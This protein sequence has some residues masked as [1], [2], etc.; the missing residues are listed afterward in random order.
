MLTRTQI[1]VIVGLTA[2]LWAAV[3]VTRGI[4]FT[5]DQFLAFGAT[6]TGLTL[7]TGW[8]NT[9]CW[10]FGIFKGWL[11]QRPWVQ[12]TWHVTL[13]SSWID[14]ATNQPIPPIPGF[15]VFRQT[16]SSLSARFYT[17]ESSSESL[18]ATILQAHDCV[19][20]LSATYRN[21]PTPQLRGVRSEIHFGAFTF[22]LHG[23]PPERLSG[24]YW[25]DRKTNGT[26]KLEDRKDSLITSFEEGLRLYGVER[27][28]IQGK[29]K[30]LAPV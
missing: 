4:P 1:T 16:F 29:S 15:M 2:V 23:D 26:M 9:R 18:A 12:G 20:Q 13:E 5:A 24:K 22:D 27:P 25:T 30:T 3:L 7:L 11:V 10:R 21:E 19:F 14:P 28:E 17:K 8:F 6:V